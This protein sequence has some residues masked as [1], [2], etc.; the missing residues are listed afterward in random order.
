MKLNLGIKYVLLRGKDEKEHI[1]QY[2]Q[3]ARCTQHACNW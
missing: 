2:V 3:Y 1:R